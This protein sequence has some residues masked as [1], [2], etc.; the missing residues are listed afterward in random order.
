MTILSIKEDHLRDLRLEGE[1]ARTIPPEQRLKNA[2]EPLELCEALYEAGGV[3]ASYYQII[4]DFLLIA[5]DVAYLVGP[6]IIFSLSAVVLNYILFQSSLVPRWLSGWGLIGGI[7][8]FAVYLLQLF[9]I[10]LEFLFILIA[11]QEMAFAVWL[12]VKGFNSSVTE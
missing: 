8:M 5:R 10:D 4:G 11:V 3:D 12:I 9:G 6:G 1:A 7:S 2:F